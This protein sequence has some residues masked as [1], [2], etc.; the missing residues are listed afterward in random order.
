MTSRLFVVTIAAWSLASPLL[1]VPSMTISPGGIQGGNWVWDVSL[2][3]DLVLA[4]GS[5]PLA[6]ELGFRLTNSQLLSVTNI[7]PGEFDTSNPGTIIFG[8]E[9]TYGPA[10]NGK[11]FGLE[12]NCTGCTAVNPTTPSGVPS[13]AIVPGTAN[14]IFAAIGSVVFNTP[15]SKPFL[16][17]VAQG[18]GNGGGSSS[19]L[20]WLG[21]YGGNGRIAQA[22]T[23]IPP[24]QNFDLYAG[25][26]TQVPEPASAALLGLG[27]STAAFSISLRRRA[28]RR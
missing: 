2:T 14:E 7:N 28:A 23:G 6:V 1:A 5:T 10:T 20:E 22:T 13:T 15:G 17:I 25:T 9:T 24:S 12:V 3:P 27:V 21:A 18:P 26:A 8:W 11:P 4:G 16:Q 19:T